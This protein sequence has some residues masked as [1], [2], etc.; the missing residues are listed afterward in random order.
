M[1]Y[2]VHFQSITYQNLFTSTEDIESMQFTAHHLI[3]RSN[4]L[5]EIAAMNINGTGVNTTVSYSTSVTEGK[6]N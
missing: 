1:G 3:P 6:Q 2:R 5:F 4:Y